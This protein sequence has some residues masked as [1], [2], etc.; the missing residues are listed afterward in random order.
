MV[1]GGLTIG[2]WFAG[3]VI[4]NFVGK[5]RSIL[6]ERHELH[7]DVADMVFNVEASLVHLQAVL[8]VAERRPVVDD[9]FTGWLELIK[10]IASE[11][12]ELLDDFE[13]KRIQKSQQ[14]KVSGFLA[15]MMKNLG[16]VDDDIYRL[17]TLL[18]RLD[19]IASKSGNF[20]DL[21]KLNDSKEDMVGF[22]PEI[23]VVFHG[24]EK[25]KDQLMSIIFPNEAQAEHFPASRMQ[26][27]TRGTATVKVVCIVGEAGVGKTALAQ[28]IY[29][30]PNVK[31]AFNQRGW[32]SL[33][34][35][36]DSEDFI[37]KIFCSFAAEQHPF[38][39]EMGLETLQASS[40]HDL[41]RTIQ[42]KRFFLVLDNAKD[43]LQREWKTVR[44]KLTGAAAGSIVLVTTRS[45]VT[46]AIPG[47]IVITLDKIPT[48][49]LSMILK[50]HAFG[51]TRKDS[52]ESIGDKIAGKLHGLPLSA[53]VIGRLLRTKLDEDHWRNVCE[54][55]WWNDYED[56]VITN[57]A[58]PSV[59][60]ALEFLR[61]DLK[62]CLGYC[63]MFPSSYLFD[64]RKMT[65]MW[66]CNSMQQH[67]ESAYEITDIRWLDELLN[68][69]LIQ[70]TVWKGKY[71]VNEMIK[72]V[73]ASINQ[74]GCYTIDDLHSPRQNLS[75]IIHMAVDKY[76]FEVSLDLRKQSKVRSILFFD[77]QRTTMLNTALNSIL[78]VSSSL[79]VL[80][81]SCIE[82][83]ME[84]PPDVISTCSHLRYLDL[85]FT[86]ITMFPDS[87]CKLLLLQVLGM[88]GCRFTE[89]PR[90]MNKLVNM[91]Y[92]YAEACTLSL[93]HSIG[94]LSK[95]QYLEEFA[96]SEKEGYR[97][98]ELKD[99]NYLGGHLCITNLEKVACVNEVCDARHAELSKKMYLQKL[100]LKWNS[101]PATLDGC[102]ETVSHLKPNGQLKDLEIHCYMG[103]KFPGWIA[104]DQHFTTLRYIKFSGCKKLVELP[105][106][107]N[108]SHLAVLILQ[109]LEQIKD[110][111]KEFYG[112]YDRVFPSLEE[113]TFRDMENWR[114]WMDIAPTQIIPRIRK[115]VIKN[116]RKL[117]DL[118]KFVLVGSHELVEL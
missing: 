42:N 8:D 68:R 12:E 65:Q 44:A 70:S 11:A 36:S 74:T 110:I 49:V 53:E 26:E 27:E 55:N 51:L 40:E 109:G 20:F 91:R 108:L 118:P 116:C 10:K 104:D 84:R 56:L 88:R 52:L 1:G 93:I 5:A 31:K 64:K 24:R 30:H 16:F 80:D 76:D 48:S 17:K 61:N 115:I 95:L 43:N 28:V 7:G 25:E 6:E 67:Q 94:Q 83:K 99:L 103:V 14:N 60:I 106:L 15:Y 75:N 79:R 34:Q 23:Q 111:G 39:S 72:K 29:N 96:V 63:S 71:T 3:A 97:I 32:V 73:V 98:T 69:S 18:A 114:R 117:V 81:L 50:H 92:L 4:A 113:L 47:G 82:T 41:S 112:S 89:L 54:S 87:F 46:H 58:L 45:E 78:P 90:D 102:T 35:R 21:L 107:G 86:G 62:K 85:S 19:K 13:I 101:Q 100:A 66:V 33:S 105:P 2:G 9:T 22:L 37:K 38:D 59:T 57:P 77:G